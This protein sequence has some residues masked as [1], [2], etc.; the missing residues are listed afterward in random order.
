MLCLGALSLNAPHRNGCVN[1]REVGATLRHAIKVMINRYLMLCLCV[2]SLV[3]PH[4]NGDVNVREAVKRKQEELLR[5]SA[6]KGR[7]STSLHTASV[8]GCTLTGEWGPLAGLHVLQRA[9]AL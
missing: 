3:A 6:A 9:V 8:R 5:G 1:V 2:I 4:R 7:V